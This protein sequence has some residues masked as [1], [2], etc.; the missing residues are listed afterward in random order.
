M[1]DVAFNA[2]E[3]HNYWLVFWR[4]VAGIPLPSNLYGLVY[5]THLFSDEESLLSAINLTTTT[6]PLA[7]LLLME[8]KQERRAIVE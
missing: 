4:D 2:P 6:F 7:L 5:E 8:R 1:S 3:H